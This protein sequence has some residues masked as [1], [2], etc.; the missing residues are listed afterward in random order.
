M[1]TAPGCDSRLASTAATIP[2][3]MPHAI[4]ITDAQGRWAVYVPSRAG[5]KIVLPVTRQ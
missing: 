3:N 2:D 1:A 4:T 5:S